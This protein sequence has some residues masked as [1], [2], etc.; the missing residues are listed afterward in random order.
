[1]LFAGVSFVMLT[2]ELLVIVPQARRQNISWRGSIELALLLWGCSV[3]AVWACLRARRKRRTRDHQQH[4]D[5]TDYSDA[6][7][8]EYSGQP[9]HGDRPGE[10]APGTGFKG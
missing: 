8:E 6:L 4:A 5:G 10:T 3:F 2:A 1:V 9:D 7:D